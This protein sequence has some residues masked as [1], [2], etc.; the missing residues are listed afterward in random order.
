MN[1]TAFQTMVRRIL[2]EEIKKRVPEMNGNGVD[3]TKKN[4]T[5]ASDPNT[6]DTMTKEKMVEELVEL[7]QE[8]DKTWSVVWDDHDDITINGGDKMKVIITPLWEDNFKIVYYPRLEDRFFFTG[9]T[10]EQV[11]DF[12]KDNI[13]NQAHYT[14]VEKGRDKSWRNSQAE[15]QKVDKGLPQ[16]DKPKVFSTDKPFT[17]EKNKEKRYVENEVKDEK[18]LPH[19]PMRE[20]NA[21]KKQAEHKI[22]DPV[23]LRKRT[24]DKKLVIKQS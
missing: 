18:D 9:L 10:W 3:P 22:K 23:K 4:K 21:P 11:K 7:V 17:K 5:F 16:G 24:P 13:D 8:I 6:R 14:S 15:D 19:Q 1:K 20:V 2:N 12:V